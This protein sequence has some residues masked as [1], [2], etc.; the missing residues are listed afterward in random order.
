MPASNTEDTYIPG[1]V[2]PALSLHTS[3]IS[4]ASELPGAAEL[5]RRSGINF[6]CGGYVSVRD[7]AGEAGLS[8]EDLLSALVALER[9]ASRDAPD[10]TSAL[11]GHLL[12]RYHAVHRLELDFLIPLAQKV[13]RVHG[14]HPVA[15]IGLATQ[16]SAI[17]NALDSH[18][19]KEEQVLFPMML[20]G[21]SPS[22][23]HPIAH[24][25]HEHDDTADHLSKIEH[26]TH[27]MQLPTGACASWTAL[28]TGVKKFTDD[29]VV[30]MHLENDVLFPRFDTTQDVVSAS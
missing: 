23:T 17:R 25:R 6:C 18:M 2:M 27:G 26:L 9:D 24:M 15:P 14:D 16:L 7:A 10:E 3:V 29:L 8:S 12:T 5:F 22:I 1:E 11:I 4:I 30:H 19:K 13:E 28:Y 20:R 21:G